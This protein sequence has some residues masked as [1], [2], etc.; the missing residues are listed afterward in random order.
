VTDTSV[1]DAVR[2]WRPS[3]PCDPYAVTR[4]P[5]RGG[6]DPTF[7]RTSDGTIWRACRTPDGPVTGQIVRRRTPGEHGTIVLTAWGPGAAW[8]CE[9]GPRFLGADDDVSCFE[10]RDRHVTRCWARDPHWRISRS[11]LVLEALA[12]AALEQKVTG[13]EAWSGWRTLVRRWGEPAPGPGADR[14]LRLL[15]APDVLAR[16][17]SWE[18]LRCH[19]DAA[20]SAVVV[21]AAQRAAALERTL[22]LPGPEAEAALRSLPGVGEWTAAEVRQRAHGDPDA[23]SFGDFHIA[24]HV[25]YALT[26]EEGTDDDLRTLLEDDRPHRYRI[27]HIV[28]T[29]M[30]GPERRGP[31]MPLRTHLPG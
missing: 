30:R 7:D 12:A 19:V 11:G 6:G 22:S 16:I 20:R 9:Y 10:P 18:W 5:R 29:R 13:R 21:L 14:G 8:W 15:P 23:V 4:V 3:W 24:R 2:E 1:P 27:Q 28:T 26:G 17:P 25:T 31:R